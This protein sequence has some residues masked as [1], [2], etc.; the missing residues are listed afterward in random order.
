ERKKHGH[1]PASINHSLQLLGQA[2]TRFLTTNG[3]PVPPIDNL[4]V[5][6]TREGYYPQAGAEALLA[7]LP[8]DLRDFVRWS[9]LTGWRKG[10]QASLRWEFVDR[11]NRSI[12]LSWRSAKTGQARTMAL[13]GELA[14]LI[15]RRWQ[16]RKVTLR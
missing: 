12:R 6:N 16:A 14:H 15:D 9:W 13:T 3:F 2:I 11:E 10:E 4:P 5:H 7:A 8:E 1:A